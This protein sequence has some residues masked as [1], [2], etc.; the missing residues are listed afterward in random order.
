MTE[1]D[2]VWIY[3]IDQTRR[4]P[5]SASEIA[6]LI[7][8]D[9][10]PSNTLVWKPGM[11]D[12]HAAEDVLEIAGLCAPPVPE[13]ARSRR[14]T[15]EMRPRPGVAADGTRRPAPQP[16]R[17]Q[18]RSG[19]EGVED[20]D[21]LAQALQVT[22]PG[23]TMTP[24]A[25]ARQL[26]PSTP[27]VAGQ[28]RASG[29]PSARTQDRAAGP[30][31]VAT[32]QRSRPVTLMARVRTHAYVWGAFWTLFL[33]V[34]GGSGFPRPSAYDIDILLGWFVGTFTALASVAIVSGAVSATLVRWARPYVER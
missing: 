18:A 8:G 4:G 15:P 27:S 13:A 3:A 1:A 23:H 14:A 10:L 9:R 7:S 25:P 32:P 2:Q 30:G 26:T 16:R 22:T 21:R 31:E 33:L 19:G 34:G 12:W 29:H 6:A 24:S 11:N 20:W 17:T 28:R 5:A